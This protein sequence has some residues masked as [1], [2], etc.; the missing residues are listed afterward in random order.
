[1]CI[2]KQTRAVNI[3]SLAIVFFLQ[4]LDNYLREVG[5]SFSVNAIKN[6]FLFGVI[7]LFGIEFYQKKIN[8]IRKRIL[9]SGEV[10][11]VIW[12]I[13]MLLCLSI[14]Q[15]LKNSTISFVPFEGTLKLLLPIIAAFLIVN[16]FNERDIYKLMCFF[17]Y[18]SIGGFICAKGIAEVCTFDFGM[19]SLKESANSLLESDFFSPTAMS[20]FIYFCYNRKSKINLLLAFIFTV[21]THKRIMT[22]YAI[23]LLPLCLAK[24][25]RKKFRK[26]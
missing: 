24:P 1:M 6:V 2:R 14:F 11:A 19:L 20:L 8:N 23:L 22:L 15:M 3:F 21:M 17:L 13:G 4:V 18:L 25:E 10:K 5:G 7:V 12:M 16:T 26:E 9:L